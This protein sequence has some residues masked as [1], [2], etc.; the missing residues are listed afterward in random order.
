[1]KLIAIDLDGTL[2]SKDG[3]ISQENKNAIHEVQKKGDIIVISSGR[4]FHDT[5]YILQ[6]AGIACPFITGNGAISFHTER[7]IQNLSLPVSV[8]SEMIAILE[9][10]N[11]YY[12]IYTKNGILIQKKGRDLLNKEIE[13]MQEQSACFPVKWAKSEVDIQYNQHGLIY[14]DQYQDM[15]FSQLEVYKLF[16]LSFDKSKLIELREL[17]TGRDNISIT[18]SGIAKLEIGHPKTSKGKALAFMADYL[19]IPLEKTV[20]IGDNLNDLPMFDI[21]GMSIA[22]GNA[23]EEVKKQSTYITTHHNENG[24]AHALQKHILS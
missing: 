13:M 24:V 14:V 4:S 5:K 18:T 19:G 2:L 10:R 8:I 23:A 12:E 20:T 3:S 7:F 1:M 15:E 16:V 21:A 9:E 6:K 22:M 17:L 11:V